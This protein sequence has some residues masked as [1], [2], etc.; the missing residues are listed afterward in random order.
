MHVHA[1]AHTEKLTAVVIFLLLEKIIMQFLTN[2]H[3]GKQ[4]HSFDSCLLRGLSLCKYIAGTPS[5]LSSS[6]SFSDLL[7]RNRHDSKD[8]S[9]YT[10]VDLARPSLDVE[11]S[12]SDRWHLNNIFCTRSKLHLCLAEGAGV[13]NIRKRRKT[14]RESAD[15]HAWPNANI[16]R[17][18]LCC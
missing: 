16:L 13:L 2:S 6:F 5:Q 10:P 17:P 1:C 4:S 12:H 11:A 15:A 3:S 9:L 18:S 7:G 14:S 8:T